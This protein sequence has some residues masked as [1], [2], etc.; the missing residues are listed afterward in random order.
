MGAIYEALDTRLKSTVALKQTLVTGEQMERA[1]EREAQLLSAL[2]HPALPHV[3]DYF[4]DGEGQFLVMQFIPGEDLGQILRREQRPAPVDVVLRW[5]DQL[6]DVLDYLHS[7]EPPILHRDVKPDNLKLTQRGTIVLLDFGLAKGATAAMTNVT[8]GSVLGYTPSYA[9][10]EQIRGLGTDARSDL[11]SAAA[12]LY[13]LMTG[14]SPVDAITRADSVLNGG[15]D[16]LPRADVLNPQIPAE[17]ADVLH[18]ALALKRDDRPRSAAEMRTALGSATARA[19]TRPAPPPFV[20]SPTTRPRA[21]QPVAPA[22][23]VGGSSSISAP[24]LVALGAAAAVFLAIV[25]V[26]AFLMWPRGST[27]PAP[28]TT[29][30]S[31]ETAGPTQGGGEPSGLAQEGAPPASGNAVPKVT[32]VSGGVLAGRAVERPQ[33]AYPEVAEAAGIEGAVVVEVT[34]AENGDVISARAV[35]GHPLLR[36]ASIQAA[37]KWKFTP[38]LLSGVPVKVIGT[39]TFRF[40]MS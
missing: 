34:V 32:R 5:A 29:N 21:V 23:A 15:G 1:F 13:A 26:G 7:H 25:G 17:V 39:I 28:T 38:T 9:P 16:P 22:A 10:L 33:P 12:T 20:D 11:Y 18:R 40:K 4:A 3:I 14:R 27:V 19:A 6:L 31:S 8:T 24:R 37:R 30:S 35:S 2:H 36:D